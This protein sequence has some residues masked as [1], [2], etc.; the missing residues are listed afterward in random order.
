MFVQPVSIWLLLTTVEKFSP[1]LD[2]RGL[3][4]TRWAQADP[5]VGSRTPPEPK[6]R[7]GNGAFLPPRRHDSRAPACPPSSARW[8]R[9]DVSS[10]FALRP[11][12]AP[13]IGGSRLRPIAGFARAP[14]WASCGDPHEGSSSDPA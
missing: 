13:G 6:A 2:V 4:R 10:F 3:Y 8:P 9:S 1:S 7:V 12:A 11:P 5:I 14:E